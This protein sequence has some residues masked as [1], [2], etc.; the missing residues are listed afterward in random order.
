MKVSADFGSSFKV[1]KCVAITCN[2]WSSE[3]LD[4]CVHPFNRI[5][6]CRDAIVKEVQISKPKDPYSEVLT[7][8]ECFCGKEKVRR[9]WLC[10]TCWNKLS[11]ETQS[12]LWQKFGAGYEKA[13]EELESDT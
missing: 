13:V 3:A 11:E 4:H 8:N 9:L 6:E 1:I 2:H 12:G 7:K 10:F 5:T